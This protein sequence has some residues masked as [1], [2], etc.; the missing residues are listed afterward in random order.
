[1]ILLNAVTADAT[2]TG[3][4][5]KNPVT[6]YGLGTF[7]SG[8]VSIQIAPDIDGVAGTYVEKATLTANGSANLFVFGV[9]W[10]R[11]VLA[12]ATNPVL[13]VRTS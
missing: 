7:G 3:H 8:T 1:M 6:V 12:G 10:L 9:Y 5:M 4:Q 2:G 11:A 13:S